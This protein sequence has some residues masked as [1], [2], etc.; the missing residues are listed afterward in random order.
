M[1]EDVHEGVDGE[2]SSGQAQVGGNCLGADVVAGGLAASTGGSNAS[3]STSSMLSSVPA[4]LV[5][6]MTSQNGH[7]VLAAAM[8]S[9]GAQ[10]G[11]ETAAG[12]QA[13]AEAEAAAAAAAARAV[14]D[15]AVGMAS[16]GGNVIR[17]QAMAAVAMAEADNAR[18]VPLCGPGGAAPPG[19]VKNPLY[20]LVAGKQGRV[21]R[22]LL[23]QVLRAINWWP[24]WAPWLC[25]LVPQLDNEYARSGMVGTQLPKGVRTFGTTGAAESVWSSLKEHDVGTLQ[26]IDVVM[27]CLFHS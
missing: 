13:Q 14:G 15:G 20:L 9:A 10:A 7:G 25:S 26:R 6:S 3:G 5:S 19:Y 16:I 8:A 23:D 11:A 18:L 27:T 17:E 1:G 12:A 22:P 2:A 4:I 24:L 21:C